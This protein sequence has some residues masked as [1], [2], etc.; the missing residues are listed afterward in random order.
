MVGENIRT[1]RKLKKISINKLSKLAGVSLGFLSDI[2]N[3]KTNPS[4]DTLEKISEALEVDVK[5][6]FEPTLNEKDVKNHK[7]APSLLEGANKNTLNFF[8]ELE[9]M[10]LFSEEMTKEEQEYLINII[11]VAMKKPN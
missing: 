4:I 1:I 11:K 2:E 8:K 9:E 10:G 7:E 5:D 6:F 3:G